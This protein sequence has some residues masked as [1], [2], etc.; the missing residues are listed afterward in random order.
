MAKG[1]ERFSDKRESLK[2]CISTGICVAFLLAT[3]LLSVT[4]C[5]KSGTGN[6]GTGLGA[7][8][9]GTGMIPDA[10][11]PD[12]TR[13]DYVLETD[14][15]YTCEQMTFELPLEEGQT[16]KNVNTRD[17]VHFMG[18]FIAVAFNGGYDMP[19]DVKREYESLENS[20]DTADY[21]RYHEIQN[22]YME[23]GVGIFDLNGNPVSK[24]LLGRG[25]EF[26]G[27][28]Q[29]GQDKAAVL[30]ESYNYEEQHVELWL[31]IYTLDGTCESRTPID[32]GQTTQVRMAGLENG[33]LLVVNNGD[34]YI[35]ST[36]GKVL[37]KSSFYLQC[38]TIL[39]ANGKYYIIVGFDRTVDG[40]VQH[41]YGYQEINIETGELSEKQEFTRASLPIC[42]S[43]EDLYF[44]TGRDLSRIDMFTGQQES[45]YTGNDNDFSIFFAGMGALRV[46][47][48]QDILFVE[49]NIEYESDAMPSLTLYHIQKASANPHAGKKI[50]RVG[51]Y[52]KSNYTQEILDYNNRPESKAYI[53]MY[54]A[55]SN[56][57]MDSAYAGAEAGVV[58][59]V[60]LDMKSGTGPDV[61][62]N[63]ADFAQF[64]NDNILV[65]LNPYLDGSDG[66]DRSLYYDNIFRAFET[67]GK[68]YQLPLSVKIEALA[69]NPDL[70][71]G[72]TAWT[73]EQFYS[74]IQ[75]NGDEVLPLLS[76][77]ENDSM[78]L[79]LQLLCGDMNHYVDYSKCEANFD[80]EDFRRL[81]EISKYVGNKLNPDLIHDLM[82]RYDDMQFGGGYHSTEAI[83]MEAG[84]CC[85][86]PVNLFT[87][88]EYSRYADLCDG[89]VVILGWPTTGG[90]GLA[91][92]THA[93]VGISKF[94][95]C[96]EEAWDFVKYLLGTETQKMRL[97]NSG[98]S[99]GISIC[100]E[101][102]EE[103]VAMTIEQDKKEKE[104]K[105]SQGY[106]GPNSPPITEEM[107]A[108][109]I[110]CIESISTA[111]NR[112]PA[113]FNI[114][115]EEAPAFFNGD[116]SAEDVSRIIQNRVTTLLEEQ[117]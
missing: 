116:R 51:T 73:C 11:N 21:L 35:L 13:H 104:K 89:R 83:V 6:D 58:D 2:R 97:R 64:N 12:G 42:A 31:R 46:N 22:E 56:A 4:A 70:L 10:T 107:G 115:R 5:K 99:D 28:C 63:F 108:A 101:V 65:D 80:C 82:E 25:E 81:L 88:R 45:I 34:A 33:N 92:E 84:L 76:P 102:V 96:K 30:A 109:F 24:L 103:A 94:S 74:R 71:G 15:Y 1:W 53:V 66:I 114:I 41:V 40:E 54:D 20:R 117:N 8:S 105:Q 111:V 110:G 26:R 57:D 72:T 75:S 50:L 69:G 113:V 44:F 32:I 55:W 36:E 48:D 78:S 61:L 85:V 86:V 100:R 49:P 18:D 60:L 7:Q 91:A 14:P 95:E 98:S 62:L 19:D 87:L 43:G 79:L 39:H 90:T 9:S 27:F 17:E 52:G 29:Y 112:N 23:A 93:S 37:H 106:D 38:E 77:V 68:L 47:S 67:D 59:T 3:M 16:P